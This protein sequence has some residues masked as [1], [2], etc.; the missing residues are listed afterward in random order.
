MLTI[1]KSY[2]LEIKV[3]KPPPA[4]PSRDVINIR[5]GNTAKIYSMYIHIWNNGQII[6]R[7][8]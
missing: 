5:V 6:G 1:K 7:K 8:E 4:Q 2:I 3:Q